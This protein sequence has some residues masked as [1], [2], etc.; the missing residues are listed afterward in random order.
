MPLDSLEKRLYQLVISRLDGDRIGIPEYEKKITGLVRKGIGGFILFGGQRDEIKGFLDHLQSFSEVRLFIASDTERG[1]G[2]QVRGT[3]VFPCQMA[4]AAAL[5]RHRSDDVLLLEDAIRAF[6]LEAKDTGINMPLIPVLDVNRNPDNPIICTRAFSDNPEDVSW[7]GSEYIRILEEEGLISC[8]KHFPGHGDTATDSH[9]SL[10]VITKSYSSLKETDIV[11]FVTAIKS[12]VGSVMV[13]HLSIPV[14]DPLPAS[15]SPKVIALLRNELGF[16]GLI[17]TD[18]LTMDA[19]RER[20]NVPLRCL[21][22]GIDMLLHPEDADMTVKGLLNDVG[23]GRLR[24]SQVDTAV[25]R[26]LTV[27]G[28]LAERRMDNPDYLYHTELSVKLTGMSIALV[29]QSPGILPITD[30][31]LCNVAFAGDERLYD[32]SPLKDAFA[33]H[34]FLHQQFYPGRQGGM[35]EKPSE[36]LI[37]AI[38]TSV[39]AWKGSSGI[40]GREEERLLELIRRAGKSVVI[41]FGSPYVLRRF[42][43]A[44]VLIA[45]YDA[46]HSAQMAV[47]QCLTGERDCMG[48]LPVRIGFADG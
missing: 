39:S 14:I 43:D 31:T 19:L 35:G 16:E 18:A 9:I 26:I 12:K 24:E 17:L 1:V 22:A 45:A 33:L 40:E 7:F 4:I 29:K 30:V 20:E 11:P 34:P 47:M 37:T 36:I 27:K 41:S 28:R 46:T 6:A 23:V 42:A 38:F 15:L 3:T 8:A 25:S 13:G 21:H 5:D 44:D 32:S 48:R 10:P 2:Q